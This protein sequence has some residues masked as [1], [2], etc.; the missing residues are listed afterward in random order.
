MP[1]HLLSDRAPDLAL[2]LPH[3]DEGGAEHNFALLAQDFSRIG[4]RIDVVLGQARGSYLSLL[5]ESV[6]IVDLK[7][8]NEYAC[9][10]PLVRYLRSHQPKAILSSLTLTTLI[11]LIGQWISH[12]QTKTV[13][14]V[15]NTLSLQPRSPLLKYLEKLAVHRLYPRAGQVVAVSN[16]VKQDLVSSY[17]LPAQRVRVIFNPTIRE[18][19]ILQAQMPVPHPW[20]NQK[21]IPVI[22][23]AGRLSRQKDFPTLIRAFALLRSQQPAYLA[24][25]GSGPEQ[26]NLQALID[27]LGLHTDACLMGFVNNPYAFMSKAS[28]FCHSAIYEGLP[29]VLIE[30]LACGC[31]VVSTDCPGGCGEILASGTFGHLAPVGDSSQLAQAML[32]VLSGDRRLPPPTWLAQFTP[33]TALEQYLDALGIQRP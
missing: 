32:A 33:E 12:S 4:L 8:K 13:I 27:Q 10:L 9:L 28:L 17:H 18:E 22:L 3:L 29:N 6:H 23:A 1:A 2:F 30:A 21:E 24:I 15:A 19:I 20:F 31:P 26:S 14:R 25:M 11:M 16:F 5:P 7:A